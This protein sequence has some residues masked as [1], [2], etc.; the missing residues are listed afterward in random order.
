MHICMQMCMYMIESV[1][2]QEVTAD[3]RTAFSSGYLSHVL[4]Y[5]QHQVCN[6]VYMY[7]C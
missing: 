5:R 2:L 3:R 4:T 1:V 6:G 7:S